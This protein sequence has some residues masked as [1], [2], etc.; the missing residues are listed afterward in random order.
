MTF[1]LVGDLA[2]VGD[3]KALVSEVEMTGARKRVKT[4]NGTSWSVN[5]A[6]S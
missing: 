6:N 1:M 4:D 3:H 5:T 2:P